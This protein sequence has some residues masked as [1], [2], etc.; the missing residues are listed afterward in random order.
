MGSPL[1]NRPCVPRRTTG[2]AALRVVGG[3]LEC[4]TMGG[5][6][7]VTILSLRSAY[8]LPHGAPIVS[9]HARVAVLLAQLR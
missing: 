2:H 7:N 9:A 5:V 1:P 4:C 6:T 3:S 8:D